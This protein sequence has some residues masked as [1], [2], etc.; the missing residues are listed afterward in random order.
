MFCDLC[1]PTSSPTNRHDSFLRRLPRLRTSIVCE[2]PA[3]P[4]EV[5]TGQPSKAC[6]KHKAGRLLTQRQSRT[7]PFPNDHS[8][9]SRPAQRSCGR[10]QAPHAQRTPI[11]GWTQSSRSGST[12][13]CTGK[14]LGHQQTILSMCKCGLSTSNMT[15]FKANVVLVTN[16]IMCYQCSAVQWP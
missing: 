11:T 1:F 12:T 6:H 5:Y 4:E 16:A 3:T 8:A 9:Q 14:K 10:H 2:L 13:S 15:A 7:S